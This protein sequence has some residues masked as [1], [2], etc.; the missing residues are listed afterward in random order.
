ML[1]LVAALALTQVPL[2]EPTREMSRSAQLF[3]QPRVAPGKLVGR[4]AMGLLFGAAPAAGVLALGIVTVDVTLL[5]LIIT[6]PIAFVLLAIGTPLGAAMFGG[7]YGK[8]F[9]DAILVSLVCS[10]FSVATGVAIFF[11]VPLAPTLFVSAAVVLGLPAIATPLF[12]QL[13]KLDGPEPALT[14]ATF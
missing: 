5:S 7:D 3:S 9:T 13:F 10:V 14:V 11:L 4:M 1:A 6:A 8:D 2:D 12:V